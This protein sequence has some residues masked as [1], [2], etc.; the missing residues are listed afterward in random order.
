M[1]SYQHTCVL[2]IYPININI[3]NLST[4]L[5]KTFTSS[6]L[7]LTIT[8]PT[9][10][11]TNPLTSLQFNLR[12]NLLTILLPNH[13]RLTSQWDNLA[14][15]IAG[16]FVLLITKPPT[17]YPS[18]LSFNPPSHQQVSTNLPTSLHNIPLINLL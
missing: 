2:D 13:L 10:Y 12:I 16:T 4:N 8:L 14:M 11:G 6:L 3:T 15:N 7:I 17:P 18:H 9:K 1:V 5:S